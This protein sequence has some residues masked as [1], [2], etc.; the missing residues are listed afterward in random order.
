MITIEK[1]RTNPLT[2]LGILKDLESFNINDI[3]EAIQELENKIGKSYFG[4]V[5]EEKLQVLYSLK[6]FAE[7]K[8][9]ATEIFRLKEQLVE[10]LTAMHGKH[11]AWADVANLVNSLQAEG[12]GREFV[13]DGLMIEIERLENCLTAFDLLSADDIHALSSE[14]GIDPDTLY[15]GVAEIIAKRKSE[16]IE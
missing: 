7:K 12:K 13:R 11:K 8:R 10:R 1:S 5:W 16:V 9:L 2:G 4:N 15:R 6:K 3:D 14:I